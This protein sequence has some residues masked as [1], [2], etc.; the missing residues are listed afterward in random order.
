MINNC[1]HSDTDEEQLVLDEIKPLVFEFKFMTKSRKPDVINVESNPTS[2][3]DTNEEFDKRNPNW[4]I[5]T[6]K[7][8]R[9]FSLRVDVMNKTFFRALRRQIKTH[10]NEF[11]ALNKLS[12]SECKRTFKVNLK[13]YSNYLCRNNKSYEERQGSKIKL[14]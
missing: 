4:S 14:Y 10:F 2:I 8:K 12:T 11:L 5:I 7:Y 1:H 6:G 3:I 9:S 13:R